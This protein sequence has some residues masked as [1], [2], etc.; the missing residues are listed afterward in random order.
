VHRR[1]HI[2]GT[3]GLEQQEEQT[4]KKHQNMYAPLITGSKAS[5]NAVSD[6]AVMESARPRGAVCGKMLSFEFRSIG[7]SVKQ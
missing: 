2:H 7:R 4:L 5:E 3:R 1:D 6:R